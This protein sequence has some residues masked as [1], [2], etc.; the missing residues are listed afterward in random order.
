VAQ[1][2]LAGWTPGPGSLIPFGVGF[3]GVEEQLLFPISQEGTEGRCVILGEA[4][5]WCGVG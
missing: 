3:S 1:E 5:Q 4:V 2:P